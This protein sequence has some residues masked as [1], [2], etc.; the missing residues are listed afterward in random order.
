MK[1]PRVLDGNGNAHAPDVL[2]FQALHANATS[3][4]NV[5]I[6]DPT[7]FEP[8]FALEIL[9]ANRFACAHW[10]HPGEKR[11]FFGDVAGD[12]GLNEGLVRRIHAPDTDFKGSKC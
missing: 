5:L 1:G 12:S 6:T 9:D 10:Q 11:A 3:L 8:A 7:Y 4:V 2:L